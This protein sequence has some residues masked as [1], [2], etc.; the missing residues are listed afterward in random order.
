MLGQSERVVSAFI[1]NIGSL[2]VVASLE[3]LLKGVEREHSD[4]LATFPV[5]V[6]LHATLSGFV[7]RARDHFTL[8]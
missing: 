7:V 4:P 6:E 5:A 3:M 2:Y 1:W 8:L